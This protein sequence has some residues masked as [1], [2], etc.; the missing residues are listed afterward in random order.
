MKIE[1]NDIIIKKFKHDYQKITGKE[2]YF[3]IIDYLKFLAEKNEELN[4]VSRKLSAEELI[5]DHIFDC[6]YGFKYFSEY[7]SICDIG[8]GGGFPGLLLAVFFE[9]KK[10]LMIEKSPKKILF[11]RKAKEHLNLKNAE[12]IEGLVEAQT[13]NNDVI[14]CRAFKSIEE[15]IMMTKKYFDSRKKYILYKARFDNINEEIAIAA[16]K[17]NFECQI[18]KI[19]EVKDKERHLVILNKK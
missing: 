10:I 17:Y 2:N 5:K 12:I 19:D 3:K 1:L 14:T 6:I 13:I 4:L 15:I 9:E 11:L 18:L 7:K 8:S 16:K